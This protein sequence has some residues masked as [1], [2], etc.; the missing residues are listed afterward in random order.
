MLA[1]LISFLILGFLGLL[2][3]LFLSPS[4]QVFGTFPNHGPTDKKVIA[5]TFD[6]G[7]NEPYTSMLLGLLKAEE[8]KATFFVVGANLKRFSAVTKQA[9]DDGHI[10][11]NHSM[12]HRFG[13]YF[14]DPKFTHEITQNQAAIAEATG[15]TPALFRPPWLFRHPWLLKTLEDLQLQPVSGQFVNNWEIFQPTAEKIASTAYRR[16]RP[17]AILIFHDGYNAKGGRRNETV[18]A[19]EILIKRLKADGYSFVTADKLLG[20]PAY[21]S[22]TAGQ[23]QTSR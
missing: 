20:V 12:N 17:G 6:D 22:L 13:N 19:V 1:G 7:P 16:S 15:Q 4:S 21:Q 11:A 23:P 5:L 18:Q 8:V 10:I 3:W 14:T 2:Y 9:Q